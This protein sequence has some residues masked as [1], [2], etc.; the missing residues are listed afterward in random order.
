MNV[1]PVASGGAGG[2]RVPPL[3]GRSANPIS[4]RGGGTL[5]PPSTTC[6]PGFSDLATA[7]NV[8][9]NCKSLIDKHQV[10]IVLCNLPVRNTYISLTSLKFDEFF[11]V[12]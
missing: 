11:L 7:L 10:S 1:R 2:A 9:R 6:P 3:F 5:S 4:T 12:H 8:V